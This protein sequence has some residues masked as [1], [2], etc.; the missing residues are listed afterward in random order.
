MAAATASQAAPRRWLA[1]TASS[2]AILAARA[3]KKARA[4]RLHAAVPGLAG[5]GLVSA[6]LGLKFGGW[7]GLIASGLALLRL[8]NRL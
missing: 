4:W 7:A 3:V 2:A 6:G 8:D 1:A 5:A